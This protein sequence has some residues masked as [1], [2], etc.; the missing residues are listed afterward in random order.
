MAKLTDV[1]G[2]GDSYA[3]QLEGAGITSTDDLLEKCATKKGRGEIAEASGV[4]EK[5][6]MTWT[7][8]VDLFRINGIGGEYA[9]LLEVAGV[10]TV[11]ELAQRKAENLHAKM[12]EI[13]AQRNLVRKMPAVSV[14]AGWIEEA[15]KLPKAVTH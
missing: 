2:I 15:K 1:Q 12:E 3:K 8:H 10:D 13:N 11:P 6:I 9:E 7:N 4:S 5:L 14:V